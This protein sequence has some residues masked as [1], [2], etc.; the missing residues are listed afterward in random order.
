M[1]KILNY[2][3]NLILNNKYCKAPTNVR[4]KNSS[5]RFW[6]RSKF[7]FQMIYKNSM[8]TSIQ[9]QVV[10]RYSQNNFLD[11]NSSLNKFNMAFNNWFL[12]IMKEFKILLKLWLKSILTIWRIIFLVKEQF[13]TKKC[14]TWCKIEALTIVSKE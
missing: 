14:S 10:L 13:C 11:N 2:S 8:K 1:L 3:N 5:S 4:M 9:I 6:V 7:C 12:E